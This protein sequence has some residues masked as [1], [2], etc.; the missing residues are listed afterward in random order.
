MDFIAQPSRGQLPAQAPPQW[1]SPSQYEPP[2][3]MQSRPMSLINRDPYPRELAQHQAVFE[4]QDTWDYQSYHQPPPFPQTIATSAQFPPP[5]PD[6]YPYPAPRG[7]VPS[8]MRQRRQVPLATTHQPMA[9]HPEAEGHLAM[10]ARAQPITR[11]I[12]LPRGSSGHANLVQGQHQA[13]D[14]MG[15]IYGTSVRP[16][17]PGG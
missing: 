9:V 7:M 10:N 17:A 15:P 12:P 6:L 11:K 3:P 16:R 8:T 5:A 2:P 4:G 14:A 1:Y 13:H